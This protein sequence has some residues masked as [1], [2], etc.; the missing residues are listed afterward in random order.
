[1]S[2]LKLV[3]PVVAMTF[4]PPRCLLIWILIWLTCRA[5]SLVGTK[6]MAASR[7][8]M[9]ARI[10]GLH[11]EGLLWN[12]TAQSGRK[13]KTFYPGCDPSSDL[14]SPAEVWGKLHFSLCHSWPEPEYPSLREQWGCFPPS[15]RKIEKKK[16]MHAKV[17]SPI[18]ECFFFCWTIIID[19]CNWLKSSRK[20]RG[21]KTVYFFLPGLERVSPTPFQRFPLEVLALGSSPQTRF[22]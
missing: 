4:T 2:S 13:I 12:T 9:K 1:M 16:K 20:L 21:G 18:L 3:P 11:R 15:K 8:R 5:S 22:L 14:F 6:T 17:T 19:K 10:V 7:Q